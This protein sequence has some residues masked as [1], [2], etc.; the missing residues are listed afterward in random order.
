MNIFSEEA[1]ERAKSEAKLEQKREE[2]GLKLG[3]TK[4][5]VKK[6]DRL[7]RKNKVKVGWLFDKDRQANILP[8]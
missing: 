2:R 3:D 6:Y 8:L 1:E 4:Q 7:K 5:R